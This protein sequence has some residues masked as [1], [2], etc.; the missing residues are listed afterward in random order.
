MSANRRSGRRVSGGSHDRFHAEPLERRELMTV[1]LARTSYMVGNA[2]SNAVVT[3]VRGSN[4]TVNPEVVQFSTLG[5]TARP[6]VDYTPVQ[7]S[8][9][10]QEGE[11]TKQ[12]SIPL[13]N[14]G[15]TGDIDRTLQV[16]VQSKDSRGNNVTSN[17]TIN[18]SPRADIV[19]P[20]I[21]QVVQLR[22]KGLLTGFKISFSEDMNAQAA[23]TVSNYAVQGVAKTDRGFSFSLKPKTTSFAIRLSAAEYDSSTRTVTLNVA[24]PQAPTDSYLITDPSGGSYQSVLTDEAGNKLDGNGD[25]TADGALS[26]SPMALVRDTRAL[27]LP[28]GV[29][30]AAKKAAA[31]TAQV[32]PAWYNRLPISLGGKQR[33]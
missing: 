31:A 26:L 12:V 5:G 1:Q 18:L 25:G 16:A 9:T 17:A 28:E 19:A 4:P 24:R 29:V 13:L 15:R 7:Q 33:S 21:T 20:T 32:K 14:V 6:D 2:T 30:Q 27:N 11:F 8:V 22:K 23:A 10:F 3:L